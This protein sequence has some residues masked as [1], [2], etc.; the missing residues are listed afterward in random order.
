MRIA[1][2]APLVSPIRDP[3]LGGAQAMVADLATGLAA[4]GHD[5]DL[6]A[7]AGSV[8]AG[9][10]VM[11]AGIDSATLDSSRFHAGGGR[12][13]PATPH[14]SISDAAFEHIFATLRRHAYDVVHNHAFDAA[15]VLWGSRQP[16][17]VVHTLHLPV[18]EAMALALTTIRATGRPG[19]VVAVSEAQAAGWRSRIAIDAVIRNGIP[20]RLIP[21]ND[22]TH[23]SV[24][25]A[26]RL[27]PEK[28]CR[29]AVEIALAAGMDIDIY[30][31][32]YDAAYAATTMEPLGRRSGVRLHPPVTRAC[33]WRR[34][35]AAAAVLCPAMWEE[36]FGLIAA[37]AQAAGTPVVGFR[38]GGLS[39]VIEEGITG[40]LVESGDVTAAA[41][42]LG[43]FPQLSRQAC[44]R[45]A[46]ATLDLEPVLDAHE[47]LYRRV[48]VPE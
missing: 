3:P 21:W 1:M 40:H 41:A 42:A 39:E 15:S 8:L 13:G 7:A 22:G 37:E 45:H 5:V 43:Q 28:G 2:V 17:P 46:E 48:S 18:D 47:N 29:E 26:G 12:K 35:G 4:R 27:S 14:T 38:R 30:G 44:R 16:S 6:Y 32:P 24:V 19:A 25:F 9:V 31:D 23:R 36:P 10:R 33:L 20:T 11:D 34:M